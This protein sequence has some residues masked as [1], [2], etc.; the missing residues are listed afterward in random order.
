M[1]PY[2]ETVDRL[3]DFL[4]AHNT[5]SVDVADEWA[6]AYAELC[7]EAN[8]RLRKCDDALR[9]G[10]RGDAIRAAEKE[11]N[12]LDLVAALDF[13]DAAQWREY[14]AV[15]GLTQPPG[16]LIELATVL[17]EAYA[18]E[19]PLQSLMARHRLMAL[20]RAPVRERLLIMRQIGELDKDNQFWDE[21]IRSFERVRLSEMN[22]Q[23]VKA[24]QAADLTTIN[25]MRDELG[26]SAWRVE[27]PQTLRQLV[28]EAGTRFSVQKAVADLRGLLPQLNESYGAMAYPECKAL[29]DQWSAIAE[30]ANL[31]VPADLQEQIEPIVSWMREQDERRDQQVR[32]LQACDT[33]QQT[34][35]TDQPNAAIESAYHA[36]IQFNLE[37]PDE[38]ESRY[39][40]RLAARAAAIRNRRR[41]I[42][43]GIA[44][45]FILVAG[46]VTLM[47]YQSILS[48]EV[49]DAQKALSSALIDVQEGDVEKGQNIRKSVVEQH[50]RIL[51]NPTIVKTMA[52]IDGA[53]AGEQH[54]QD[55][56]QRA[57]KAVLAAG[58]EHP[59]ATDLQQATILAKMPDESSQVQEFK[60]RVDDFDRSAQAEVDHKFVSDGEALSAEIEK[61]LTPELMTSDPEGFVQNLQAMNK[62]VAQMHQVSGISQDVEQAQLAS[63]DAAIA[64]RQQD[65]EQ[66]QMRQQMLQTVRQFGDSASA[67]AEALRQFVKSC[68]DDPR[69]ADFTRAIAQ[70]PAEQSIEEWSRLVSNWGSMVPNNYDEAK[71]RAVQIQDY[72]NRY[73]TT[74]LQQRVSE[75]Q[76]YLN[77]GIELTA[78]D[79]PWKSKLRKM[80]NNPLVRDL[81]FLDTSDGLRYYVLDNV[82]VTSIAAG[83][84]QIQSFDAITTP[85]VTQPS[86]VEL[87][88]GQS[89]TSATPAPSEQAI[90]ADAA[91]KRLDDLDFSNFE[92]FGLDITQDL[93]SHHDMNLVLRSILLQH[94]LE[95]NQPVATSIGN[96]ATGKTAQTLAGL[97][98]DDISWLDPTQKTDPL[99]LGRLQAAIDGL[100]SLSEMS[101]AVSRHR[102]AILQ[103]A[104]LVMAGEGVLLRAGGGYELDS[105]VIGAEGQIASLCDPE[106]GLLKIGT[107]KN[108]HWLLDK[109]VI[110]S[111]PDGTLVFI[112]GPP[113]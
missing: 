34:I 101:S 66:Q 48:R 112:A 100:P 15:H 78:E 49:D 67:H 10:L 95:L 61:T 41:L 93:L 105:P 69:C 94:I 91:L 4:A 86:H 46:A 44:A 53:I 50:P 5:V 89:L 80:L 11:P 72:L 63:L 24:V 97:D 77:T 79:G 54:R 106:K 103:S 113:Q 70:L 1:P 43:T 17:N 57:M 88:P 12:L 7:Q 47:A 39:R 42:Y 33:L 36:A 64:H 32:F 96:D 14:C 9:R 74:P 51:K 83:D 65:L 35:D 109:P 37:L 76:G 8:D 29:L 22:S 16:L 19:Q 90:F 20:G 45:G 60:S 28:Q 85:D 23:I 92:A 59:D 111:V 75:Y 13:P 27:V 82:S 6:Q 58:V 21:D 81:R 26:K 25:H 108:A 56:F 62:R 38:L 2:R 52:D 102:D 98:V 99:V 110:Q 71:N 73:P 87:K 3:I 30:Q 55:K 84:S 68:P 18:V 107:Y 40:Q 31:A 104:H